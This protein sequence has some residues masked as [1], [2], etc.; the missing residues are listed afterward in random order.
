MLISVSDGSPSTVTFRHMVA[1]VLGAW[2]VTGLGAWIT[3]RFR[4][5]R[6]VRVAVIGSHEF[7][8]GLQAELKAVGS[9]ATT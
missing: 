2:V 9:R 4:D 3:R 1:P 6:E 7:A 8:R 5:E